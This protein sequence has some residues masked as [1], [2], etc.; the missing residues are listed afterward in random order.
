[1]RSTSG[2]MEREKTKLF[3]NYIIILKTSMHSHR[4]DGN[5]KE[6]IA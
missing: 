1:M 5:E 2:E 6:G 4:D 3:K